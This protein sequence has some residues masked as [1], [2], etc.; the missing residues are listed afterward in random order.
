METNLRRNSRIKAGFVG[1]LEPRN[2]TT[3]ITGTR[4]VANARSQSRSLHGR[5]G[6]ATV[7]GAFLIA[8]MWLMVLH[9]TL[10]TTL[11]STTVFGL[12]EVLRDCYIHGIMD[13]EAVKSKVL[14]REKFCLF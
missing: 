5:F 6:I 12:S 11:V 3:L 2:D 9:R 7:G 1:P 10:Y 8:P 14:V 13:G 4:H